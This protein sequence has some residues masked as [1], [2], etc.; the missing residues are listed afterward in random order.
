MS[1][2]LISKISINIFTGVIIF[3]KVIK[4]SFFLWNKYYFHA[5]TELTLQF[6]IFL[7]KIKEFHSKS[8]N[9]NS[10]SAIFCA[11]FSMRFRILNSLRVLFFHS[12][13]VVSNVNITNRFDRF[14]LMWL[15]FFSFT[16]KFD[17]SARFTIA[18]RHKSNMI[19]E[20]HF[21][22]CIAPL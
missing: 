19:G 21:R 6:I 7:R 20:F 8:I 17:S 10:I 14:S 2:E 9:Q 1:K 16:S 5:C 12:G 11:I 15:S 3:E 18:R 13:I 4:F 22:R